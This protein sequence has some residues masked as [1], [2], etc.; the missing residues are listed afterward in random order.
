MFKNQI[1][2]TLILTSE[3]KHSSFYNTFLLSTFLMG[4]QMLVY[5]EPVADVCVCTVC[6]MYDMRKYS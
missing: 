3:F 4:I 5:V 6:A 1:S 2:L